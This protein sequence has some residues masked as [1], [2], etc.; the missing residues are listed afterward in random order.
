MGSLNYAKYSRGRKDFVFKFVFANP[1]EEIIEL[2]QAMR[3]L[4]I[5]PEH[6]CFDVGTWGRW[7]RFSTRA[8]WSPRCTRTS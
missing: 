8:C 2:L 1:F 6:E 5:K 7:H 3:R 4:E